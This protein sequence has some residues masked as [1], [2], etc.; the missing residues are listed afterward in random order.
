MLKQS[1]S[2]KPSCSAEAAT[3]GW[4]CVE[5]VIVMADKF[6]IVAAT[7]GWLCVETL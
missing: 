7:F 3:F 5:T 1:I 2:F 6:G 4:L